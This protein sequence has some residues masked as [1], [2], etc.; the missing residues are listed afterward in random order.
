MVLFWKASGFFDFY[1]YFCVFLRVIAYFYAFIFIFMYY[2][3][4]SKKKK[5]KEQLIY[6]FIFCCSFKRM[7]YSQTRCNSLW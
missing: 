5:T 6:Y 3:A 7:N 4:F 2:Y 1:A